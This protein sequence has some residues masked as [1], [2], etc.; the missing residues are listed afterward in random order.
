MPRNEGMYGP[1]NPRPAPMSIEELRTIL[2]YDPQIGRVYW[3]VRVHGS[4]PGD[5]AG[6]P[7]S[8]GYLSISINQARYQAHRI[9]YYLQTAEWPMDLV[10]HIN[11]DRSDNRWTNLRAATKQQN[12][13]NR[14]GRAKSGFKGVY[15]TQSGKWTARLKVGGRIYNFPSRNT[16]DEAWIDYCAAAREHHGDFARFD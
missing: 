13:W 2:R 1:G 10:D 15:P 5:T 12:G 7:D 4:W 6:T 8:R 16:P 14:A 9:A 11:G 3:K